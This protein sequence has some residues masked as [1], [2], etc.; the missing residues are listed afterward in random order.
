MWAARGKS[1]ILCQLLFYL[2]LGILAWSTKAFW[3]YF[4]IKKISPWILLKFLVSTIQTIH[5]FSINHL[6]CHLHYIY[7]HS[8]ACKQF[9][10][11]LQFLFG[12]EKISL[13][14][15]LI[16]VVQICRE[17]VSS[18]KWFSVNRDSFDKNWDNI[19]LF[20]ERLKFRIIF[21]SSPM[22]TLETKLPSM[23]DQAP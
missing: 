6:D 13:F 9:F 14:D 17:T 8:M 3:C 1:R 21:K 18:L 23:T 11:S 7:L 15:L 22:D 19:F 20:L 4:C 12:V 10:W 16:F 2:E 5:C